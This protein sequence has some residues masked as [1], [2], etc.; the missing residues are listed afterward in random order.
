MNNKTKLKENKRK[1]L[2]FFISYI[3]YK[4]FTLGGI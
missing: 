2:L 3:M 4:V 1:F